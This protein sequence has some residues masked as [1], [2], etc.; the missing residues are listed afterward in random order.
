MNDEPALLI[1]EPD[2]LDRIVAALRAFPG[3]P[4]DEVKDREFVRQV[5]T[6]FP[7]L[8]LA[9]QAA[10]WRL[11]MIDHDEKG[12]EVRAR[13]RFTNWCRNAVKFGGSRGTYSGVRQAGGRAGTRARTADEFGATSDRATGW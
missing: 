13:A 4:S 10:L 9:E 7:A 3:W 1:G 2:D 12:K 8:D 5:R 6:L 11:W